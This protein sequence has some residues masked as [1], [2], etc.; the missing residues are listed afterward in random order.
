M[1]EFVKKHKGSLLALAGMLSLWAAVSM[2]LISMDEA[3]KLA[4]ELM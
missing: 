3:A 4:E 1:K 2:G